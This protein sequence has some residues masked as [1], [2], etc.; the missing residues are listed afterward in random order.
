MA[1]I[2]KKLRIQFIPL[3]VKHLLSA[4]HQ[5]HKVNNKGTIRADNSNAAQ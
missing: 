4:G 1:N 2:G 5:G 3:L